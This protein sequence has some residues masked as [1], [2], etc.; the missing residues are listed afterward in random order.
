MFLVVLY[1]NQLLDSVAAGLELE[2]GFEEGRFR[3]VFVLVLEGSA[4]CCWLW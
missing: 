4:C 3:L 1:K 2:V